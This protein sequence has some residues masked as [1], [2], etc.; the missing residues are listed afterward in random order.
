ML[1]VQKADHEEDGLSR[2]PKFETWFKQTIIDVYRK[3]IPNT[4]NFLCD[5]LEFKEVPITIDTKKRSKKRVISQV[6]EPEESKVTMKRQ[7]R[8]TEVSKPIKVS[9][10]EESK[11]DL[12]IMNSA[13]IKGRLSKS[14]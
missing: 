1:E 5:A 13:P 3:A 9:F 7:Y 10:R 11:L 12:Q 8:N 14:Q 6:I 4:T 2:F